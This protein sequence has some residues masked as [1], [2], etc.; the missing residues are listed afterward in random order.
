M[1]YIAKE[2]NRVIGVYHL[3]SHILSGQYTD[4]FR[5]RIVKRYCDTNMT[6]I[7]EQFKECSHYQNSDAWSK[8]GDYVKENNC[9]MFFNKCDDEHAFLIANGVELQTILGESF[10]FEFYITDRDQSYVICFNHHDV[11]YG[12]GAA[13]EWVEELAKFKS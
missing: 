12:C 6:F 13:R 3:K 8:S 9:I 10:G 2:I 11:L 4:D 7:W 5:E 1:G